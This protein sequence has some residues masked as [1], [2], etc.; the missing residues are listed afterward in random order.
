M[1]TNDRISVSRCSS[2]IAAT[3]V[4]AL[5]IPLAAQNAAQSTQ[6]SAATQAAGSQD[7]SAASA[8]I[9]I[10]AGRSSVLTTDFDVTRIA[11]T[12]PAVADAVVVEPRQVLIDC[13]APGTVSLILWG[14]DRRIQY[15]VVVAP[16]VSALQQQLR[17]LFPGEDINVQVNEEATTLSG[18]VSSTRVMLK[19]AEIAQITSSKTKVINLLQVPGGGQSE[20]V[21]LQVRFAE[22]NRQQ[23]V[24]AGASIF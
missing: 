10:T 5:T 15:D 6:T 2:L 4:A 14:S 20:Q 23:A 22:V 11:I 12:N 17:A 8:R 16:P 3:I 19:A 21:L 7:L 13:K 24:D 9:D 1:T 18:H